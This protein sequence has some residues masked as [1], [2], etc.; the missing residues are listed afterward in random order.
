MP[1]LNPNSTNYF[2]SYEPNT[3]DLSLAMDY[4]PQGR[5]VLRTFATDNQHTSKD[6]LRVS[7][8]ETLFFNTFQYSKETDV[9][10]ES[11]ANGGTAVHVPAI[12]GI[13]MYVTN[14][15]GSEV[16]RQTRQVMRYIPGR[17][18]ETSFAIRLTTPTAGIRRR[19][20]MF[21]ETDG[22]YFED[23]GD[24]D[25]YCVIRSSTSGSVV[26]RRV[27]RAEWNGDKLDGA[28]PS[29]FTANPAAQQ[30]VYF[31]YEW[32]GAGAV[33]IKFIINNHPHTIHTFYNA[34]I[35][36]TVWCKS[37][38]LPIRCEIK[39]ITGGQA[40]DNYH[41]YQGSNSC[42]S[43][44]NQGKL[45]IAENISSPITGRSLGNTTST[46]FPV[47]SIRMDSNSLDSIVLPSGFQAA[48]LD[49]TSIF[50]RL[51]KNGTLTDPVWTD[52]LPGVGFAEYDAS[53]TAITGGTIIDSGF[54]A[55]GNQGL[56]I[57][58]NPDARYQLGRGSM[59]TVS[60]TLTVAIV[61]TQANKSGFAAISWTELR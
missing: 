10:D 56:R 20:G 6:R 14:T 22:F 9:W 15:L 58:L 27:G 17:Q 43:D 19:F 42:I 47:L 45:G 36:E 23:G 38:F 57:D 8:Y 25:F 4:D 16:V 18:S 29:G 21:T 48:T 40:A 12:S 60:D 50:Y 39:N 44:G 59:G 55:A 2:H 49:N 34:N 13:D 31:D 28:G 5:P 37:P 52:V 30:I 7:D 61:A 51:I 3:N 26:E 35:L 32:Y 33:Q 46:F 11:T 54:I 41:M 24:G 1:N 53:A